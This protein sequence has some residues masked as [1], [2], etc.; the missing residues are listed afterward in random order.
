MINKYK[1]YVYI[2]LVGG[3]TFGFGQS[4][5]DLQKLRAEYEKLQKGQ[6]QLQVPGAAAETIDPATGL[7]RQAQI[8]PYSPD[9]QDELE[10]DDDRLQHFGYN[11]F[12]KRDTL[13]FWENLPTPPNYLLGPGDELVI[14]LWGET[15]LRETYTIS[16]DGK[17]YDDKVGLLNLTGRTIDGA[18]TYLTNQFGRVYATLNGNTPTTFMDVSLGELR[19]IN[20]NFVGQVKYPGVYPIHP[21]STVIT[22]LIQAGGVDT[23]GSLRTIE[24]KR[25]GAVEASIDLYQYLIKGDMPDNIQLRDQDIVVI[26]PRKSVVTIDSA[27]VNPGIYE[28]SPEETVYDLIQ[29][30]GGSNHNASETVGIRMIKPKSERTNGISYESYYVDIGSTKLIPVLNADRITVRHLF[31]ELNQVE[32]IGQVKVPGIYNYH[33]GMTLKTLLNLGGGFEDSTFWKTVY[34]NQAEIIRRDPDSRYETV[35]DINLNDIYNGSSNH[36]IPLQN[37]DRVIIHA[38][39][40]YFEKENVTITGEVNI[41]GA[42]PLVKDNETLQSILN[43]AGGYTTKA[44]ENGIS[45]YRDQKYFDVTTAQNVLA[46]DAGDAGKVRVAWQNESIALMSGDSIVVK[47]STGTVNVSGQVY[48]PGLIEFRKGRNLRHYINA[49]GGITERGNNKGIIVVYANGVVSPNKWYTTPRIED[50]ATIIVNEKPPEVPFDVTQ[51]ATNWTS[52]ISSMITAI[53]LSKQ[54]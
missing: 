27:V 25:N 38:N 2:L 42:Y 8:T 39:L 40:N 53:V 3:L 54:L 16:K 45:I 35:I 19:S 46:L 43:R 24:I 51:F 23:T 21:F 28:A 14:S 22:G 41:P 11:F 50:G 10:K 9:I 5:Q 52:I 30:A 31:F 32:I 33:K 29:Y 44:L 6:G 7:P 4:L 20:V 18:R 26:H 36:D 17:I 49:A 12:T 47:E 13:P 1:Q 48:N 15:Q 37:L 34:Q